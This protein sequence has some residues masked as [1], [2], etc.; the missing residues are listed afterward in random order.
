MRRQDHERDKQTPNLYWTDDYGYSRGQE[1]NHDRKRIVHGNDAGG[2][3]PEFQHPH[4]GSRRGGPIQKRMCGQGMGNRSHAVLP[5]RKPAG[6]SSI[7]PGNRRRR[8][9]QSRPGQV[10]LPERLPKRFPQ[11]PTGTGGGPR[12]SAPKPE[13]ICYPERE[14]GL[15]Y[16]ISAQRPE[17]KPSPWIFVNRYALRFNQARSR[18]WH[19]PVNRTSGLFQTGRGAARM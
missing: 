4:D 19:Q 14:L 16:G 5:G 15:I 8:R 12:S 13:N 18:P 3:D 2:V 9:P 1:V 17:K 6:M 7:G 10:E 11:E